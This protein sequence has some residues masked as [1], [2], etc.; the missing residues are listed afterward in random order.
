[1]ILYSI[2]SFILKKTNASIDGTNKESNK[3]SNV[4]QTSG[5]NSDS[6]EMSH[7]KNIEVLVSA[8][9]HQMMALEESNE[10]KGE[11][12]NDNPSI[13][14]QNNDSVEMMGNSDS[15]APPPPRPVM[16]T[17][18]TTEAITLPNGQVL[19]AGTKQVVV[20]PYKT[21]DQSKFTADWFYN[22]FNAQ[23]TTTTSQTTSQT[24]S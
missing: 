8:A 19:P 16:T 12:L 4:G 21:E 15:V 3:E 22:A 23:N 24:N 5:L 10:S 14:S 7:Q 18:S 13:D 6:I 2:N 11:P 17:L 20:H 9:S 1:M